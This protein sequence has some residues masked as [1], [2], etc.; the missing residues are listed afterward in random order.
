M[1]VLIYYTNNSRQK[2]KMH[3]FNFIVQSY[4]TFMHKLRINTTA[5]KFCDKRMLNNAKLATLYF[6]PTL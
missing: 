1:S 6:D 2:V 3:L 4:S 5:I